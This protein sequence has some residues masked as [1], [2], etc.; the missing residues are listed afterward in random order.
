MRSI[1]LALLTA[2][3]AALVKADFMLSNTSICMGAFPFQSCISGPLVMTGVKN[4]TEFNCD[5]LM[6]AEDHSYIYNGTWK[7]NTTSNS[8]SGSPHLYTNDICGNGKLN[9]TWDWDTKTYYG[10]KDGSHVAECVQDGSL[11]RHCNQWIG[12]TFFGSAF[13]CNST[14][15]CH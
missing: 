5:K 8:P 9:F 14:I 11:S 10:V 6:H 7:W 2:L 1:T 3:T 13:R 15:E 12:A 4:N